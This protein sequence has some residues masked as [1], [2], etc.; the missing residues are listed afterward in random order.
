MTVAQSKSPK[1]SSDTAAGEPPH[2]IGIVE[3]LSVIWAALASGLLKPSLVAAIIALVSCGGA[4]IAA[5]LLITED[6]MMGPDAAVYAQ[7]PLDDYCYATSD[8]L[9][10]LRHP[11]TGDHVALIGTAAMRE[12]LETDQQ[13]A[14]RIERGYGKAIPVID[15]MSGGQ[16]GI[17]MAALADSLG[18]DYQGVVV[19][20]ISFSRLAADSS[21]LGTLVREPRLAFI[22]PAGDAEI[23]AA[24]FEPPHRTGNYLI[25]N[26]KFFV[27][28]YRSIL[29][30]LISGTRP[31]H[32]SRTYL[33]RPPAD[34]KQWASDSAIL[35]ARIAH[36]EE[37]ADNNLGAMD[38]LIRMFPDRNKVRIVLLEIPLNPR[39]AADIVGQSFVDA[40]RAR[41]QAFAQRE[42]VLYWDLNETAGLTTDDFQDWAHINRASAKDRWTGQLVDRLIPLIQTK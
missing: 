1:A 40:H 21:E 41:M 17:E 25:D 5:D 6:S 31:L 13:I 37:R 15:F 26:Y 42:G 4:I 11:P 38:R 36:Y 30:H 23:R 22:S 14:G 24:G 12:A 29:W 34:E 19:L 3:K 28:R 7:D 8:A 9:R 33:G 18:R 2:P 20:G 27:A 10:F 32:D 39:A 16:S 35:K